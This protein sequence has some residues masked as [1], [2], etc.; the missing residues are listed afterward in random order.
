VSGIEGVKPLW[1]ALDG[2]T[3]ATTLTRPMVT[4]ARLQPCSRHR[5]AVELF[6][7]ATELA[8]RLV[9]ETRKSFRQAHYHVGEAV[10]GK[11]DFEG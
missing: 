10:R 1:S 5:R 11:A 6:T 4:G 7:S 9:L 3:E 2:L 8:N